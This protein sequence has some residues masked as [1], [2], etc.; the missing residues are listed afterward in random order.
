MYKMSIDTSKSD[1]YALLQLMPVDGYESFKS[2]ET[3]IR[4]V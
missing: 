1:E 2:F 3:F 4:I